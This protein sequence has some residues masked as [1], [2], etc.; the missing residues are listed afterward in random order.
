MFSV[1]GRNPTAFIEVERLRKY[2]PV[3]KGL[4]AQL[5][6]S[7]NEYVHAVDDVSLTIERG[8]IFGL[9][10]ES[11]SGKTTTGRITAGLLKPTSG[12]V[13]IDGTDLY[14]LEPAKLRLFRERMQFVFQDPLSSLNPKMTVGQAVSEPMRYLTKTSTSK[15]KEQALELLDTVGL[16]PSETF[17]YRYP[18]QLSGGQRQRV[19]IARAI[20]IK[21]EYLIADEPVA[22]V[23]VSVRAQIMEL[24]LRMQRELNLTILLI[25]HDLAVAKYMCNK[26]SVMYLGK[27]M[28]S[29][30]T[31]QLFSNPLHPYTDALLDA[32]PI[33]N[34]K[35]TSDKKLPAGEIPSALN[36]PAGCGFHPR[37]AYVFERCSSEEPD[38]LTQSEGHR[39]AC[40]LYTTTDKKQERLTLRKGRP[41]SPLPTADIK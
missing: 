25:T 40:H 33:P 32:V 11:G 39:V 4:L 22:M 15:R 35:V 14:E 5:F 21:P 9:V 12:R 19:V 36:P 41:P 17:Y 26:I 16:S 34:P 38:L 3:Q 31:R 27:I 7:K 20:S 10:G 13:R 8:D 1:G 2:F 24:L 6:S 18:H 30:T 28:E 37:C 29:S 23:D